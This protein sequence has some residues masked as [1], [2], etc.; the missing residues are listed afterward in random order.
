MKILLLN[1]EKIRVENDG[2]QM[3]VE[4]ESASQ[5]YSPF[6]MLASGLA[7]CT[8]SVIHSW[9]T[10]AKLDAGDLA[11]EVSWKFAEKPHRVGSYDMKFIWPSLPEARRDSAL[12]AAKLCA[13]HATFQHTPEFTMEVTA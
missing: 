11:V 2:A 1:D 9:A 10:H 12:R 5:Q 8:Y 13:A 6:H 4:A 3:T 7:I